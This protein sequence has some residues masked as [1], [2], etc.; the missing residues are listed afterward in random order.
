MK[1]SKKLFFFYFSTYVFLK[2]LYR[3]RRHSIAAERLIERQNGTMDGGLCPV[4]CE[5]RQDL[6]LFRSFRKIGRSTQLADPV[7]LGNT[8]VLYTDAI[9]IFFVHGECMNAGLKWQLPTRHRYQKVC[10]TMASQVRN[11]RRECRFPRDGRAIWGTSL[12]SLLRPRLDPTATSGNRANFQAGSLGKPILRPRRPEKL[13][14]LP[15]FG[16]FSLDLEN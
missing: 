8:R 9:C 11:T 14:D 16:G 12:K 5:R 1:Q 6:C 15:F 4:T 10:V 13:S 7:V 3:Q 2:Y